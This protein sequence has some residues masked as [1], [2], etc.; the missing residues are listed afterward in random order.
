MWQSVYALEG[1]LSAERGKT[2]LLART[3]QKIARDG[4]Q[5][6]VASLV[7][8]KISDGFRMLLDRNM[9]DLTFEAVALRHPADFSEDVMTTAKLRLMEVGFEPKL[10]N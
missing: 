8:G 1:A 3:R 2:T 7:V 10:T 4:E 6:T 9:T 5:G